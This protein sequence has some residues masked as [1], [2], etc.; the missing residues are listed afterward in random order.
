MPYVAVKMYPKD[1]ETRKK[2]AEK[3]CETVM[4]VT[5][6]PAEAVT[7]SLEEVAPEDWVATVKEPETSNVQSTRMPGNFI[8]EFMPSSPPM[9]AAITAVIKYGIVRLSSGS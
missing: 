6:C 4:E 2:L 3:L 9:T 7:V 8:I 5:G 1:E